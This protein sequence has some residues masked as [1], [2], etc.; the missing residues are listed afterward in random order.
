MS[1][2]DRYDHE[3][4]ACS[5]T[6]ATLCIYHDSID[7]LTISQALD[8]TPDRFQM[9]GDILE[10]GNLAPLTGWFLGTQDVLSSKDL[11]AHVEWLL[12]RLSPRKDTI[13]MLSKAGH[14]MWIYC[15]WVSSSGNGGPIFDQQFIK[16]LSD[17]PFELHLDIWCDSAH[18]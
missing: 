12:D 7:P 18:G 6:Y 4:P 11:R 14:R 8:M 16:N 5:R 17:F 3:Y 15:F 1:S 2:L 10:S 13:V 9:A